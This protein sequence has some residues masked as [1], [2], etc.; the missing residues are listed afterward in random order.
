MPQGMEV[1]ISCV[2]GFVRCD[3]VSFR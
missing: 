2:Q 1:T 3:G